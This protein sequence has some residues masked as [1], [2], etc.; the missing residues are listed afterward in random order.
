CGL[1]LC[2][3]APKDPPRDEEFD[4]LLYDLDSWPVGRQIEVLAELLAGRLPRAVAVHGYNLEDGPA[5]ALRRHTVAVYRRLQPSVFRFLRR[6]IRT[7][8]AVT[9]QGRNPQDKHTMGQRGVMS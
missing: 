9:A 2:P 5:E 4:A 3:L 1:T 7:V 6:A 8:H